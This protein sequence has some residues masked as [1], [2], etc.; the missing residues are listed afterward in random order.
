MSRRLLVA[1]AVVVLLLGA[2]AAVWFGRGKESD[3]PVAPPPPLGPAYD[4]EEKRFEVTAPPS[5]PTGPAIDVR[6]DRPAGLSFRTKGSFRWVVRAEGR[7]GTMEPKPS[8]AVSG[9]VDATGTVAAGKD[10]G[11]TRTTV[12]G[13]IEYEDVRGREAAVARTAKFHLEFDGD[14]KGAAVHRTIDMRVPADLKDG[15]EIVQSCWTGRMPLVG[16]SVHVGEVVAPEQGIDTDPLRRRAW[17]AF[18]PWDPANVPPIMNPLGGVWVEARDASGGEDAIL[19]RAHLHQ[20]QTNPVTT[21]AGTLTVG[22]GSVE[23]GAFRLAVAD[24]LPLAYEVSIL[25]SFRVQGGEGEK[26]LDYTV[27]TFERADL[28]TTRG[29]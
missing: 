26:A 1:V 29:K 18:Y 28:T 15:L 7:F 27:K 21:K 3:E 5:S 9:T 14:G 12:E 16:R 4:L 10:P 13:T 24:A 23:V 20:G 8:R 11:T 25:G 2:G 6:A 19:V 22:Y 17:F